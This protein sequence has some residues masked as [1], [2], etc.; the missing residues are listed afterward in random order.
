VPLLPPGFSRSISRF[1]AAA[2]RA[3]DRLRGNA[4]ADRLFYGASAIGEHGLVWMALGGLLALRG[5][6]H[7]R[8]GKRVAAGIIVESLVVN[9]GIK[10]LFRRSRPVHDTPRP[11]P[12]RIPITSSFPSG[13][14]SAAFFA[15]TLLSDGDPALAP[16]YWT[17]AVIVS[18]SRIHVKIHHASDVVGGMVVGAGLGVLAKGLVPLDRP[19]APSERGSAPKA[20]PTAAAAAEAMV[21]GISRRAEGLA[22]T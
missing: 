7:R 5:R 8:A 20:A 1:D 13:H 4:A 3:F 18:V 12:L 17:L 10:S 21:T 16:V 15:A 2:D 9:G 11:L 19:D 22:P 6:E 14:A